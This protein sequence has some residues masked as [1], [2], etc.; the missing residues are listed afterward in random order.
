MQRAIFAVEGMTCGNCVK[1]VSK[2]LEE[3]AGVIR[4][5]PPRIDLST[6]R[7]ELAYDETR[8]DPSTIARAIDEAGYPARPIG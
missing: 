1:H 7:V 3:V 8:V 2:A 4:E 5:D 6:G